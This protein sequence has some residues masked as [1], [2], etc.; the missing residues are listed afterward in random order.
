MPSLTARLAV[1][2]MGLWLLVGAGFAGADVQQVIPRLAARVTDL[3]ST[4]DVEQRRRLDDRLAAFE[5][6]KGSQIAVL[7]VPTV[8][9]ESVEQYALR[10]VESWELGRRGVDDGALLL[11]AKDDR[12]LRIE[13]GYGLEGALNDATAKRII[14]ETI[15]PRFKRGDF[16]G[17][18]D[19]GIAAM[20]QVIAGE[21]L[22]PA[23]RIEGARRADVDD[24]FEMLLLIGFVLVFVVGGV[25]RA[26]FG[27]F[28]AAGMVGV[29]AGAIAAMLISSLLI[30]AVLGVAAALVS[31]FLGMRGGTGWSS[32]G[33][34]WG[35]GGGR[36]S[37]GFSGGGG[38]FGGGG[39]SGDW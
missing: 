7:I 1:W 37:G 18:I 12:K 22:P 21:A 36:S 20:M 4:L 9:P 6:A 27:R 34:S 13:V 33:I 11:I 35:G 17:G 16:Y 24:H 8:Q 31:L 29:A 2:L 28:L 30:A 38:S 19:A 10:V 3:T 25:L 39:A 26:I 23:A 5:K 14:S 32:G 15:A